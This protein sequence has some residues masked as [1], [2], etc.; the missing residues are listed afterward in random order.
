MSC[1]APS[2]V[3]VLPTVCSLLRDGVRVSGL[4]PQNV[5]VEAI[6]MTTANSSVFWAFQAVYCATL[7]R[8]GDGTLVLSAVTAL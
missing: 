5:S 6:L 4:N 1:T 7:A 3:G 2:T 8:W